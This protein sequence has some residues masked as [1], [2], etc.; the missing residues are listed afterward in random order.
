MCSARWERV[1][2]DVRKTSLRRAPDQTQHTWKVTLGSAV[3]SPEQLREQL[4]HMCQLVEL[5]SSPGLFLTLGQMLE[6]P[7]SVLKIPVFRLQTR[8]TRWETRALIEADFKLPRWLWQATK[9]ENSCW[10]PNLVARFML[11]RRWQCRIICHFI[12]ASMELKACRHISMQ[13]WTSVHI[14]LAGK[15]TETSPSEQ[16]P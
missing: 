13:A 9:A 8:T 12:W 3:G 11:Q 5:L 7:G 10:F 15:W 14:Y 16:N 4:S 1:S 6:I 2:K